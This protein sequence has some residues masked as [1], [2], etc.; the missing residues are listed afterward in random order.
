MFDHRFFA[1]KLGAAALISVA[2][3]VTFNVLA[4][5][6]QFGPVPPAMSA[7]SVAPLVELA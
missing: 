2:A 3:M 5:T 6:Q 7:A 1:S 4:L